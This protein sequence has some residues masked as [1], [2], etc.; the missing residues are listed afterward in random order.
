MTELCGL[1]RAVVAS[2]S[3]RSTRCATS[4]RPTTRSP[5]PGRHRSGPTSHPRAGLIGRLGHRRR[6][7]PGAGPVR[8]G[9]C[10][11][12][13]RHGRTQL[14]E[15]RIRDAAASVR[16]TGDRIDALVDGSTSSVRPGGRLRNWPRPSWRPSSRYGSCS[17]GGQGVHRPEARE[18][19]V[20]V[21]LPG[22]RR[23]PGRTGVAL[24]RH[25]AA[26]VDCRS[27]AARCRRSPRST[28]TCRTG[29]LA[30]LLAICLPR[31]P[32]PPRR[33]RHRQRHVRTT[34]RPPG[35][36]RI[37][38]LVT[39]TAATS[40]PSPSCA[41][42]TRGSTRRRCVEP[43]LGAEI[44]PHPY[45]RRLRCTPFLD[46]DVLSRYRLVTRPDDA[47]RPRPPRRPVDM[48]P[49]AV[50]EASS[51]H[52]SRRQGYD[53]VAHPVSRDDGID[54]RR[55]HGRPATSRASAR[56][57]SSGAGRSC[58]EGRPGVSWAPARTPPTNAGYLVT[59]SWFSDR[60]RQRDRAQGIG[61]TMQGAEPRAL[62]IKEHL[63]HDVLLH[64]H[65]R[66]DA[67]SAAAFTVPAASG[68]PAGRGHL[69]D[70]PPG[71]VRAEPRRL[72]R[73][74][75][76]RTAR[77]RRRRAAGRTGRRSARAHSVAFSALIGICSSPSR[78]M[79]ASAG[80]PSVV[81]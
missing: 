30:T 53:A 36:P 59:T 66:R 75:A 7:R 12:R 15:H 63:G 45:Q 62:Q 49:H 11:L 25:V 6:R 65:V 1:L 39:V 71:A 51:P 5:T 3:R 22:Q 77:G 80:R 52:C 31:V 17:R 64:A 61:A 56:S 13:R 79:S 9:L 73:R 21:E 78:S 10:R 54:G 20:E 48:D 72:Q 19:A 43:F 4:H 69:H 68:R 40:R 38:C 47:R 58:P 16:S 50:R 41:S 81:R 27:T 46:V 42:T 14:H 28:P 8:R 37:P 23:R 32:G 2:R 76:R 60:T 70:H 26:T 74:A 35:A 34:D 24:R 57:S 18:L 44:S 67:R 33:R 29:T 55:D